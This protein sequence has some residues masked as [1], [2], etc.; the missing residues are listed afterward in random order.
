MARRLAHRLSLADLREP[1]PTP[2]EM[3]QAH[4]QIHKAPRGACPRCKS[5]GF[6]PANQLRL[7]EELS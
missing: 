4:E 3:D 2:A 5:G 7:F 6:D 1:F